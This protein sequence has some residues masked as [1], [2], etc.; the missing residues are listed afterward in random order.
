MTQKETA[1]PNQEITPQLQIR[2]EQVDPAP[3]MFL[4]GELD[5]STIDELA[6]AFDDQDGSLLVDLDGVSFMD[7]S[8]I[9]TIVSARKRLLKDGG[10]LTLRAPRPHIRRVLEITGL[11]TI[12]R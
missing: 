12:I 11:D 5:L 7:S 9:R 10:E 6:S 8:G 2:V 4:T 1:M 3:I